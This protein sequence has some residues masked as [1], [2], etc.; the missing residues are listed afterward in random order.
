LSGVLELNPAEQI[1][2][3]KMKNRIA[4]TFEKFG[5][6]PLD[7]ATIERENI[8]L[9]K[10]GGDTEKEIYRIK[11]GDNDLALRFD[12]TVPLARYVS[13]NY[14]DLTFPFRR[15]QIGK[16]FRGERPQKGRFR[17]FYQ[18]DVD[19]LG[20]GSLDIKNDAEI[21]SIIYFIFN[22]L[23]IGPFVIRINN[24][25][26][27]SGLLEQLEISDKT[28]AVLRVIDK[29]EK[30]GE[31]KVIELLQQENISKNAID[32]ILEFMKFEGTQSEKISFL[33]KQNISNELYLQGVE[34][35]EEIIKYIE[36]FGVPNDYYK[37]DFSITRG[38]DY[39]TGTVYETF[40]IDYPE[41]GSICSGGRY[42]NLTEFY[43]KRNMPGVGISIGLTR[44]FSQ[45]RERGC[46]E[47]TTKTISELLI[48][49]MV[50][51]LEIPIEIA[52]QL[53]RK[54]INTEIVL[55]DVPFKKK[56]NYADK[57]GVEYI[58]IVGEDEIRDNK[59]TIKNMKSGEQKTLTIEEVGD[60]I[61]SVRNKNV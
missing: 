41:F 10:A 45:L 57:K 26:V 4:E 43:S 29:Y 16:V 25:K 31:D 20:D 39:Y 24:R 21:P 7:V 28:T 50:K 59:F 34:E 3:N 61:L 22:R 58:L 60:L 2:F 49:P 47:E 33:K 44:L 14:N 54:S 11:K 42:D 23:N 8:L 12:L 48:L 32:K 6:I 18:C 38:L 51:D 13:A 30:I 52:T 53:R 5:F 55:E 35:L 9:A 56:L 19:I 17:E 46:F 37:I 36:L 1:E 15:Y 40:L 27:L